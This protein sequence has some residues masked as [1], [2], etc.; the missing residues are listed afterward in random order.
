MKLIIIILILGMTSCV[1]TKEVCKSK[2][3][4]EVVYIMWHPPAPQLLLF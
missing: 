1:S 2:P 3:K 4:K